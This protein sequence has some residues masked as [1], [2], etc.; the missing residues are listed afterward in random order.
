MAT[1]NELSATNSL[2]LHDVVVENQLPENIK[3]QEIDNGF[4][5]NN[6]EIEGFVENQENGEDIVEKKGKRV[7][8]GKRKRKR[9]NKNNPFDGIGIHNKGVQDF[10]YETKKRQGP[11]ICY[12]REEIEALRFVNVDKQKNK[13]VE[14][15]CGLG[16]LLV[17]EYDCLVK[18][19]NSTSQDKDEGE[20]G[21]GVDFDPRKNLNNKLVA[22]APGILG[23]L[24]LLVT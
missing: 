5:E 9:Q 21:G 19:K 20:S 22:V 13:W 10:E 18:S 14:I 24:F 7:R 8:K 11:R 16:P 15:Y 3:S 17:N 23:M 2:S 1:D 6:K 4:L 12:S